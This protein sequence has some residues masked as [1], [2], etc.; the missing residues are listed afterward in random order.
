METSFQK[1][2]RIGHFLRFARE[3]VECRA[4]PLSVRWRR[5]KSVLGAATGKIRELH[6]GVEKQKQPKADRLIWL[7][8]ELPL[9]D[10]DS[11]RFRLDV[12]PASEVMST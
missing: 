12:L 8:C 4:L 7:R 11:E 3:M 1:T 10:G 5:S 9:I 2:L 6:I